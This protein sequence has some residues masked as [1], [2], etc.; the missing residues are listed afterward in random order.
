M[1]ATSIVVGLRRWLR[2][3]QWLGI[4]RLSYVAFGCGVVHAWFGAYNAGSLSALWLGG[5][6]VLVPALAATALRFVPARTLTS[7][8]LFEDAP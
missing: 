5:I 3:R 1:M 8:G 4:H 6:T 7:S 2:Y